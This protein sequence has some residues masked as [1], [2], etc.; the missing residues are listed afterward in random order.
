[1]IQH[2]RGSLLEFLLSS[3]FKTASRLLAEMI[4]LQKIYLSGLGDNIK[5]SLDSHKI[6]RALNEQEVAYKTMYTIPKI[7]LWMLVFV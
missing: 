1:M 4:K 2:F 5:F 7:G 3:T 6:I